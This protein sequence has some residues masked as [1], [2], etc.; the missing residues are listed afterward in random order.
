M[1]LRNVL[2]IVKEFIKSKKDSNNSC[3]SND[4]GKKGGNS[5]N[6]NCL[7]KNEIGSNVSSSNSLVMVVFSKWH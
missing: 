1:V 2:I 6:S 7:I 4:I 3:I 5:S